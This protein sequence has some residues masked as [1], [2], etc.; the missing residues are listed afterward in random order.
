MFNLIFTHHA[1]ERRK[2]RRIP[3]NVIRHVIVNGKHSPDNSRIHSVFKVNDDNEVHVV[4]SMVPEGAA[5][6]TAFVR[7]SWDADNR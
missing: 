2:Q 1:D 3:E 6:V 7:G 5:V 4:W